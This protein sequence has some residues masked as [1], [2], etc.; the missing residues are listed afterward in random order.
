MVDVYD[1]TYKTAL[2]PSYMAAVCDHILESH[3][4]V[5]RPDHQSHYSSIQRHQRHDSRC[6]SV[7]LSHHQTVLLAVH[8]QLYTCDGMHV[9]IITFASKLTGSVVLLVYCTILFTL[10]DGDRKKN[11]ISSLINSC[12]FITKTKNTSLHNIVLL[13]SL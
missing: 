10:D 9:G 12:V 5:R 7:T 2:V 1:R 13:A 8:V 3:S 11:V 4:L 6:I